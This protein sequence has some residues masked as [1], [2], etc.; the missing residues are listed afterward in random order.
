MDVIESIKR[1]RSVRYFEEKKVPKE[2]INNIIDSARW[3][4]SACNRQAWR[5]IVI[6]NHKL[7]KRITKEV[8]AYHIIKSPLLILVLYHNKTENTEYRDYIQ[9]ASA[10]IQNM[11]LTAESLGLGAVWVNNMPPKRTIRKVFNIPSYYTPIAF[12]SFGFPKII[13]KPLPRKGSVDDLIAYNKFDFN[14]NEYDSSTL[15]SRTNIKIQIRRFLIYIFR[16]IPP[17][18][19]EILTPIARKFEKKFDKGNIKG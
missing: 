4:P 12:V 18:L 5:F 15:F 11:L 7:R 2:F 9:S 17:S 6:S 3:A 13:P 8:T 10:A 14:I 19:R 16:R 1:R